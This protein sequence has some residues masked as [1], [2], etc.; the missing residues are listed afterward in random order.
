MRHQVHVTI[1][2]LDPKDLP[3]GAVDRVVQHLQD[4]WVGGSVC[5]WE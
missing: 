2:W 3:E 4:R 1:P 5:A